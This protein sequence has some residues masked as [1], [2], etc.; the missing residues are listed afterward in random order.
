MMLCRKNTTHLLSVVVMSAVAATAVATAAVA[1]ALFIAHGGGPMPLLNP[2]DPLPVVWQRHVADLFGGPA[3]ARPKAIVVV[4][5]H[6]DGDADGTVRVGGA[7]RPKMLYDYGGFPPESYKLQY[8]APG[9]PDVA[10][11]A[12]ALL[13]AAGVKARLDADRPYDHGVF[14]PLMKMFPAADIPV[15]P[16]SV[17]P[18]Q[19]PAAHVAVGRALA[20]LRA[21]GVFFLGS[22]ASNHNFAYL[23]GRRQPKVPG[24]VGDG[25]HRRL[26]SVFA[27]AAATAA[28]AAAGKKL[29]AD[30]EAYL[31]WPETEEAQARGAAEHFMPLFTIL[32]T[33]KFFADAGA[34]PTGTEE[35]GSPVGG[36]AFAAAAAAAAP[37]AP[38]VVY[39]G[40]RGL[41]P[42][43]MLRVATPFTHVLCE[44]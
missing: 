21:D 31:D 20:P 27:E 42:G 3:A 11:K 44:D 34:K 28:S 29:L 40:E 17:L 9:A 6:Y 12:V 15:V 32:G 39:E 36:D 18:S 2:S 8:P 4:S 5:A 24:V 10:A 37:R 19:D 43:D 1:P 7:A 26:N 38:R 14:V 13:K 16:L 22:G 41:Q 30:L 23:F 25:F 33:S 35:C